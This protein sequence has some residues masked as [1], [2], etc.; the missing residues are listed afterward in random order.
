M[1][2]EFVEIH[3]PYLKNLKAAAKAAFEKG[4]LIDAWVTIG[5]MNPWIRNADE[6]GGLFDHRFFEGREVD[7]LENLAEKLRERGQYCGVVHYYKDLC[8]I[9]QVDRGD[10]WLGIKGALPFESWSFQTSWTSELVSR[11]EKIMEAT[12]EQ[13]L[14]GEVEY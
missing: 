6:D 1:I 11:F 9:Q 2:D 7:S 8:F 4:G 13:L 10:E 5:Q 3:P 12:E 14:S